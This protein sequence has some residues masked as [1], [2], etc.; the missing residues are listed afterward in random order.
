MRHKQNM[1]ASNLEQIVYD[2][3][4]DYE[5]CLFPDMAITDEDSYSSTASISETDRHRG[6][7]SLNIELFRELSFTG[8]YQ[9][10]MVKAYEGDLPRFLIPLYRLND[11][12]SISGVCPCFYTSDIKFE[13][14][15]RRPREIMGIL[16]RYSY[17]ISPDFSV[18]MDMPRPLQVANIFR[19]K[20]LAAMW[21]I[22]GIKVIP[23]V[24]WTG[25]RHIEEDLDGWPRYSVI[26]INSTGIG[27]DKRSKYNWLE[28]YEATIDM[29]HPTAILRYGTLQ[30]GERR[31][32][33]R[34]Y[35]NCNRINVKEIIH[36]R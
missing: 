12:Q 14:V 13:R 4:D 35:P 33:S 11:A 31:E 26:A 16:M 17:V 30:E 2:L 24:S 25:V 7:G 1:I 9:M 8:R 10:P 28:G 22:A 19:N 21:Q 34:Y 20:V 23:S 18:Y 3:C 27:K 36:G 29:L 5:P 32:I 15:W 6:N